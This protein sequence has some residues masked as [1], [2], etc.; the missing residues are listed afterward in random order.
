MTN[1]NSTPRR[2]AHLLAAV[3][4][5]VVALWAMRSVLEAPGTLLPYPADHDVIPNF[6]RISQA[7]QLKE[8][9]GTIRAA[10]LLLEPGRLL[11]GDCF[12]LPNGTTF[13]EHMYGEALLA[14]VPYALTGEPIL[15]FNIVVTMGVV[16]CG[17]SMYALAWYWTRDAGA[18]FLAGLFFE[19]L[20]ARVGD[21][22]H[23]FCHGDFWLP[24]FLL[25][26]HRV[27][28]HG[29]WRDV[30]V[31]AVV[32]SLQCLESF[33]TLVEFAL[34]GGVYAIAV[35]F[36]HRRRLF[37]V[38]P[39]L[40][41]AATTI[42]VVAF[43]V[44]SPFAEMRAMWGTGGRFSLPW[45]PSILGPGGQM[46]AGTA[47]FVLAIAGVI[48]RLRRRGLPDDP[49]LPM[50][51]AGLL[52]A[53]IGTAGMMAVLGRPSGVAFMW[54]WSKIGTN[55][56][57]VRVLPLLM[58]G[59]PLAVAF[60]AAFGAA[61]IGRAI[62]HGA[63]PLMV[64]TLALAALVEVFHP[65]V[66]TIAFKRTVEMKAA[67]WRLSEPVLALYARMDDGGG[68]LDL[69]FTPGT[70]DTLFNDLSHYAVGRMFHH[71]RMA[72]CPTSLDG[73][74]EWDVATLGARLPDPTA[75][76]ALYAMG[77][78]YVIVH[79]HLLPLPK[80]LQWR[81]LR[82]KAQ[83]SPS[84]V[85]LGSA[86]GHELF[87]L[88]GTRQVVTSL[89]ALA[90]GAAADVVRVQAPRA[91]VPFVIR[92]T[93]DEMFRH[94]DPMQPTPVRL[95]WQGRSGEPTETFERTLML[96]I[97]LEPGQEQA[98]IVAGLLPAPGSYD[99][100]IAL[101]AH[102]DRVLGRATVDVAPPK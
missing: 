60:V 53:W 18:A 30:A 29:S 45:P 57:G 44:L 40:A 36:Q 82:T 12:P 20:P 91:N 21:P 81:M 43:V 51:A 3:A 34:V 93:S 16:L 95:V 98:R 13:G 58:H 48:D 7:D 28:A 76:D 33:Y 42:V 68:V 56:S 69:P 35:V 97:L 90:P 84:F 4:Y 101:A 39:Q 17:L 1:A 86:E 66:A 74:M 78:R 79:D 24:L 37:V 73:P 15:T 23:P 89:D 46:Y 77:F 55:F 8:A 38:L 27:V 67:P 47:A 54:L 2:T 50:V 10:S 96:P 70:G 19:I 5:T 99:V 64:G 85:S 6:K 87:A 26:L 100:T 92:N 75:V 88:H 41:T 52:C 61:A 63:R 9:L 102:P 11:D 62:P 49:R 83:G 32:G 14:I 65:E 25:F 71:H 59:V 94:P 72:A 22:H 31:L 80:R